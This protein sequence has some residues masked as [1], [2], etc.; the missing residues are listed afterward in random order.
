MS[1][2]R[3]IIALIEQLDAERVR[4]TLA[5]DAAALSRLIA[6][7]MRYVHSSAVDETKALYIERATTGHYDYTGLTTVKRD[8][9]VIGDV[10]LVNGD[11]KIELLLKGAPRTVMSRY[12]QVWAKRAGNWQVV[13]WQ[14][15]PIPAAVG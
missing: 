11:L 1:T 14:S 15:T 4:A 10:V 12:L 7:D 8:F 2:D 5:K 6:D 13:A 3:E 9:R